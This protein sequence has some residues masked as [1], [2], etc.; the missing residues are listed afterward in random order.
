MSTSKAHIIAQ[1]QREILSL[2][3]YK[4][5]TDGVA[6]DGG[7]CA[8]RHAFPNASFPL[9]AMHEFICDTPEQGAA[10]AG[11]IS[12]VLSGLVKNTGVLLWISAHQTIFPPALHS[13]GIKPENVV[14]VAVK[15]DKERLWVIEEA[16]KCE[17]L[18]A[19][20]G[21]VQEV[22]F[23]CSRRFQLAVEHSKVTGFIIR[24]NP[25]NMA[26]AAVARWKIA[27]LPSA[28]E[29]GLPGV[30]F[31]RWNV[32]LQKVRNGKPGTWWL[33]WAAGTFRQVYEVTIID[34]VS[35]RKA[36]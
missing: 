34:Q 18:L 30:G 32:E 7:L 23:T 3:G 1:L 29:E 25:K 21:E 11:F 22:S 4:P 36:G 8:I 13:F 35:Q 28:T 26:T 27:P 14:F 17:A 6:F 2:Q 24:H 33:E 5:A 20:I 19:V 9:A 12:G 15:K 16:L 31:P 10:T